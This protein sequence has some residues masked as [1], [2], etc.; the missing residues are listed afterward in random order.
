M[1]SHVTVRLVT[2][3]DDSLDDD[4]LR[5]PVIF[6]GLFQTTPTIADEEENES[7][8]ADLLDLAESLDYHQL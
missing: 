2:P 6:I 1:T 8:Y 5:S 7:D 4:A 3:G